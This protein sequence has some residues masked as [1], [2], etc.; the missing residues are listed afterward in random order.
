M[1]IQCDHCPQELDLPDDQI[2][3]QRFSVTCPTC[4]Q[5]LLIDPPAVAAARQAMSEAPPSE[6]TPETGP[7]EMAAPPEPSA[8]QPASTELPPLRGLDRELIEAHTQAALIVHLDHPADERLD[9]ELRRLGFQEIYH[10]SDLEAA[11]ELTQE[12]DLDF[13]LIRM[14]SVPAPPCPPLAPV[15]K[16]PFDLRRKMFVAV[17]ADNVKTLDGQVAFYLQVNCLIQ[18][19]EPAL[20]AKLRRAHLHDLRLYRHWHVDD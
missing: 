14:Q 12:V 19:A 11:G 10:A 7:A 18:S 5:K 4:S 1:R 13:M 2:P 8:E 3:T 6:P 15:Y 17:I 20:A 9:P 16:L